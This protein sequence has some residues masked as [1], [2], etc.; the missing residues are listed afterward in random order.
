LLRRIFGQP[1]LPRP[2]VGL[3][4]PAVVCPTSQ[5]RRNASLEMS[6]KNR[7]RSSYCGYSEIRLTLLSIGKA[8]RAAV[9]ALFFLQNPG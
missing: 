8:L 3:R 2:S 1:G 9:L 7:T 5:A 4:Y 6:A